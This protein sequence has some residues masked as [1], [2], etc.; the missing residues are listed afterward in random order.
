M[1]TKYVH[2]SL[3][4]VVVININVNIIHCLCN[5]LRHVS[6]VG[7]ASSSNCV[8]LH[9]TKVRPELVLELSVRFDVPQR[10]DMCIH[11]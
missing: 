4:Y 1:V 8:R 3:Q 6:C 2:V 5:T 7:C 9:E 11:Y 10:Y